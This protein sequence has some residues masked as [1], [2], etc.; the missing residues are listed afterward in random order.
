MIGGGGRCGVCIARPTEARFMHQRQRECECGEVPACF[1]QLELRAAK[2][3]LDLTRC[4][5]ARARPAC[6]ALAACMCVPFSPARSNVYS[7]DQNLY[8]LRFRTPSCR[9]QLASYVVVLTFG[10]KWTP[11]WSYRRGG[12]PS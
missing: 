1:P 12:M 6:D 2:C 3:T 7:K 4:V 10:L 11:A 8:R 9:I 5:G